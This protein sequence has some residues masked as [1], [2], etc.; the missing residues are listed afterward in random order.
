M[1]ENLSGKLSKRLRRTA[2]AIAA[3]GMAATIIHA[4]PSNSTVLVPPAD[5]PELAR[6]GGEAMLLHETIDGRTL[7][8][9]EQNQGARL[10][11]LD[12][13]DPPHV[14]GKGSVQLEASGAFDFMFPLGD[15]AELVR[16]REG[17]GDA[18]LD[19][20]EVPKLNKLEDLDY[21]AYGDRQ[22]ARDYQVVDSEVSRELSHVFDVKQVRQETTNAATGTTFVLTENGLYLIRQPRVEALH[23]MMV[24]PP[25]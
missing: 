25:N 3:S 14:K 11:A 12:V 17:Q 22:A 2:I 8:Y 24:I 23:Q 5:L 1:R 7:L 21:A 19:L 20:R 6:Q 16:Y 4:N 18:V 10:A 13:T 9:I 15:R